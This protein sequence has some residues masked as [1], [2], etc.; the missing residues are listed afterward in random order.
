MP[1]TKKK[2]F[3]CWLASGKIYCASCGDSEGG[4]PMTKEDFEEGDIVI[5]DE[6]GLRLL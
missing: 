1:I 3:I 5:C 4:K 2:D 6:C